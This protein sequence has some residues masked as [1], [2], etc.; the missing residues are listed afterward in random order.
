[1]SVSNND[2]ESD[3]WFASRFV[4]LLIVKWLPMEM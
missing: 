2:R 3:T 1:M 4:Q